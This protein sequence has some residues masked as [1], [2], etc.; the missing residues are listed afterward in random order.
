MA[1]GVFLFANLDTETGIFYNV[2]QYFCRFAP[3]IL[4]LRFPATTANGGSYT[5]KRIKILLVALLV[6]ICILP[7]CIQQAS[8]AHN[9]YPT[10]QIVLGVKTV[11]CT[12]YAWQQ[13]Y[14]RLGIALPAWSNAI[15]WYNSAANAGYSVGKTPQANSIA[16]WSVSAHNLGHVAFVTAVN[17]SNMT[18]NEGGRNDLAANGGIKNGQVLPSTVGTT[19]YGRTLIGFIYLNGTPSVSTTQFCKIIRSKA[20]DSAAHNRDQRNVLLGILQDLKQG[21]QIGYL[22]RLQQVYSPIHCTRN[23]PLLHCVNIMSSGCSG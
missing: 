17:G 21:N 18:I 12:W 4:Y 5:M 23:P 11:P 22:F 1:C 6:V 14:E 8:A 15:T 13:A 16:V 2:V 3:G 19:W 9:P 10:S 20:K 7:N